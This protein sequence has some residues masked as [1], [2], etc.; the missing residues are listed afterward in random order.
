[1]GIFIEVDGERVF[2]GAPKLLLQALN[3]SSYPSI[4]VIVVAIGDEDVIFIARNN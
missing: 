3:K 2:E 1:M 4:E